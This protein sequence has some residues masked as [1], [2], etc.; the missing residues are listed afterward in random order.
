MRPD[1]PAPPRT[2]RTALVWPLLALL[3]VACTAAL[4]RMPAP[5]QETA[6]VLLVDRA[7]RR[8][9]AEPGREVRLPDD[10]EAAAGT[11]VARAGYAFDI[12]L[13]PAPQRLALYASGLIGTVRVRLNGAV[14]LDDLTEPLPPSPRALALLR[15]IDLPDALLRPGPNRIEVD[16]AR[17]GWASLSVLRIGERD[18]LRALRDRKGLAMVVGPA[19]VATVV[20]CLGLS[21]LVLFARRRGEVVY[22]HFGLGATLWSAH[23]FWTIAPWTPLTGVHQGVWWNTLYAA[24]VVMLSLFCL[25]FA[26]QGRPRFERAVLVLAAPVPVLLYAASGLGMLDTAAE[27][28]RLAM[29]LLA[30]GALGYVARHAWHRRSTAS[31]LLVASGLAGAGLGLRDWLVFRN[32]DDNLPVALTP[33]AGLPF[34]LLVSWFLVDRF[35]R[36]AQS[37]EAINRQLEG[38]VARRESELAANFERLTA[39]ER[40]QGAG[41]ERQRILRSLH[42][43][44]GTKLLTSLQHLE[45]GQLD[46]QGVA[47]ELRS[48]LADMRLAMETLKPGQTDLAD[49]VGNFLFRWEGVLREAGVRAQWQVELPEDGVRIAPQVALQLL[50]LMQEALTNVLRHAGAQRLHLALTV[51]ADTLRLVIEDDGSG[52]PADADTRGRGLADMRGRADGLGAQLALLRAAGGGTRVELSLHLAPP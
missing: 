6:A 27:A 48:C 25:R 34:I 39:L 37:L 33:Y 7:Q 41:D 44:L 24:F 13:G 11:A 26:Q 51:R 46:E 21:M 2:R 8:D 23:T 14:L 15:V 52:L 19:L 43:G 50:R 38:R 20:G 49:A 16:I 31:A 36:T 47:A 29:V 18:L 17:R 1:L 4:L 32:G 42:D 30:T 22:A 28:L 45:R 3:V 5:A 9:A 10:V 12:D 35:A 40:E